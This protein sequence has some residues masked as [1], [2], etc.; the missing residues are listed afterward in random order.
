MFTTILGAR[1]IATVDAV[2][3]THDRRCTGTDRVRKWPEIGLVH[4]LVVYIRAD[5]RNGGS[6]FDRRVS[7]RLLFIDCASQ[8][9]VKTD[10][11]YIRM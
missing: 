2:I 8:T 6:I 9:L 7:L 5:C 3:G 10:V 1:T 11:V 4:R